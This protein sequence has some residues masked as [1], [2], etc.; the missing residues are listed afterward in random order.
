MHDQSDIGFSVGEGLLC[1]TDSTFLLHPHRLEKA[2]LLPR[3]LLYKDILLI[4]IHSP[5]IL[6]RQN[7]HKFNTFC[8]DEKKRKIVNYTTNCRLREDASCIGQNEE[9][10][11]V[12]S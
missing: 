8:L 12:N 3:P 1:L 7:I 6:M 2:N 11:R 5:N 9:S 4:H 10:E